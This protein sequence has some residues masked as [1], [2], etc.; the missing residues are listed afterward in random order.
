[1][2]YNNAGCQWL[3]TAFVRFMHSLLAILQADWSNRR[4]FSFESSRRVS[5]LLSSAIQ[6]M[7]ASIYCFVV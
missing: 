4:Y 2:S 6:V 7:T 1:M 5:H 3:L